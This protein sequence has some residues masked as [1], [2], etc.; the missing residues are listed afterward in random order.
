MPSIA[1]SEP[2]KSPDVTHFAQ[3]PVPLHPL[4]ALDAPLAHVV[5]RSGVAWQAE[6]LDKVKRQRMRSH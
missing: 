5:L 6:A 1:G 2:R 4:Q 3:M